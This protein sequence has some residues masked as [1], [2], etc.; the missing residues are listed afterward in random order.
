MNF[1]FHLILK[2]YWVIN[3]TIALVKVPNKTVVK[4]MLIFIF[5]PM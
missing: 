1:F 3:E 5:S 2:F 4:L